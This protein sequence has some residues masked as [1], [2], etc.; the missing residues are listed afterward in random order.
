MTSGYRAKQFCQLVYNKDEKK[1]IE[2][3]NR[4]TNFYNTCVDCEVWSKMTPFI[5]ACYNSLANVAIALLDRGSNINHVTEFGSSALMY[6]ASAHDYVIVKML[7]DRGADVNILN[8]CKLSALSYRMSD[9]LLEKMINK[10]IYTDNIFEYYDIHKNMHDKAT[11]FMRNRY[12]NTIIM[13]IND[14]TTYNELAR[15]FATTY[16]PQLVD[17]I[18]EFI[19]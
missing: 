17:I 18:C 16:V 1:C 2:F 13:A 14:T 4:Y 11:G 7:L 3:I 12:R 5:Y 6:A 19:I 8:N 10:I 9:E 15:S